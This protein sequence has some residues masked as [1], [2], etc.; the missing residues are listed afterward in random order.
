MVNPLV[1]RLLELSNDV[2]KN[3]GPL[4]HR[5]IRQNSNKK[6]MKSKDIENNINGQKENSNN[7]NFSVSSVEDLKT[8]IEKQNEQLQK[9][10]DEIKSL[11]K[12]MDDNDK[13]VLDFKSELS[14]VRKKWQSMGDI[15]SNNR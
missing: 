4:P 14:E 11:R 6:L 12:K 9:Q 10:N 2:E 3:P 7:G 15:R 8:I 13:M 5:F 1:P